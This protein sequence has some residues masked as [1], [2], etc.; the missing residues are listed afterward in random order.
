MDVKCV[1]MKK[2]LGLSDKM[3]GVGICPFVSTNILL[4]RQ[5]AFF[6]F[7]SPLLVLWA[8]TLPLRELPTIMFDVA[9][10]TSYFSSVL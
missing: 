6:L 4:E 8:I 2:I 7:S 3:H 10:K 9:W 1:I 5:H